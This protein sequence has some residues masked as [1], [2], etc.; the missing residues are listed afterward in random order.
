MTDIKEIEETIA[1]NT[2]IVKATKRSYSYPLIPAPLYI[3]HTEHLLSLVKNANQELS[4]ACVIAHMQGVS[5]T[6]EKYR[7]IINAN[8]KHKGGI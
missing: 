6:E 8:I 7:E 2:K 5:D 4:D 3:E 1:Y